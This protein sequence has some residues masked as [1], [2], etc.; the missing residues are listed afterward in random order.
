MER[1]KSPNQM[2]EDALS[3]ETNTSQTGKSETSSFGTS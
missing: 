2:K 1:L 3:V